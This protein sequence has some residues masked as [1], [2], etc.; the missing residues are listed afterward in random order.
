MNAVPHLLARVLMKQGLQMASE[1]QKMNATR[2]A[3]FN[4]RPLN[5]RLYSLQSKAET[6]SRHDASIKPSSHTGNALG[7]GSTSDALNP[8]TG[9]TVREQGLGLRVSRLIHVCKCESDNFSDLILGV[10]V[11]V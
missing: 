2:A 1:R 10:G 8:E 3:T 6:K 9:L 11:K 4:P 5:P 7:M